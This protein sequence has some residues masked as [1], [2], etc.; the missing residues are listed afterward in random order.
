MIYVIILIT[1]AT[2]AVASVFFI[3]SDKNVKT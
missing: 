2:I 1:L 3:F